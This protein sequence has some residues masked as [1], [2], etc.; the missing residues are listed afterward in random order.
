MRPHV[1]GRIATCLEEDDCC[2][3]S[4][5]GLLLFPPEPMSAF[6]TSIAPSALIGVLLTSAICSALF[7]CRKPSYANID[8]GCRAVVTSCCISQHN[9]VT[10]AGN[11]WDTLVISKKRLPAGTLRRTDENSAA[12]TT[13]PMHSLQLQFLAALL[14]LLFRTLLAADTSAAR[15]ATVYVWPLS[16]PSPTPYLDITYD[17]SSRQASVAKAYP[18]P[19]V[20][21]DDQDEDALVRVGLWDGKSKKWRGV[22]T[23]ASAIGDSHPRTVS[24]HLDGN[25]DAWYVG[26]HASESKREKPAGKAKDDDAGRLRVELVTPT[27]GPTPVL[28]KPLVLD[29]H[30]KPPEKEVEK[31]FVQK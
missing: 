1:V 20:V 13:M 3:S 26:F 2:S 15:T 10:R 28:N 24:L 5:S 27:L 9:S 22:V 6:A 25:G 30:G 8:D 18:P 12:L 11:W 4:D 19:V 7:L 17:P 31:S 29:E 23:A 16:A 14:F 21:A